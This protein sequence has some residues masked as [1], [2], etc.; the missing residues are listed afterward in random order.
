MCGTVVH[1]HTGVWCTYALFGQGGDG[2]SV[3]LCGFVCVRARACGELSA[4]GMGHAGC[5]EV[6]GAEPARMA[7][8]ATQP[9]RPDNGWEQYGSHCGSAKT[10]SKR[11]TALRGVTRLPAPAHS[12]PERQPHCKPCEKAPAP[13]HHIR[14]R[15]KHLCP[16]HQCSST[17]PPVRSVGQPIAVCCPSSLLLYLGVPATHPRTRAGP[18]CLKARTT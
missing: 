15:R 14:R 3:I 2:T 1:T 7:L 12:P 17:E 10:H 6:G 16:C 9:L 18:S 13:M 11:G 8:P 4:M 5:V